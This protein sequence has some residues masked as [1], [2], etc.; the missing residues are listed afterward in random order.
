MPL[1]DTADVTSCRCKAHVYYC[2][3]DQ[4]CQGDG[5]GEVGTTLGEGL[6]VYVM[7]QVNEAKDCQTHRTHKRMVQL[8]PTN[9]NY[10]ESTTNENALPVDP[11]V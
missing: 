2:Y 5:F 7:Q 8:P 3:N 10:E 1:I 4:C 9:R 11:S 6:H